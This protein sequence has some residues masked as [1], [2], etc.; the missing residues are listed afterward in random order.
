MITAVIRNRENT[1]KG[2]FGN[3]ILTELNHFFYTFS[4]TSIVTLQQK[5]EQYSE[6]YLIFWGKSAKIPLYIYGVGEFISF[7]LRNYGRRT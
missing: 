1:L 2:L 6:N 5:G 7:C 4:L 3:L